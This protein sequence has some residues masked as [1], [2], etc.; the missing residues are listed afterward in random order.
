MNMYNI[1]SGHHLRPHRILNACVPTQQ[2]AHTGLGLKEQNVCSA[3]NAS[4]TT[5]QQ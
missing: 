4:S 2:P 3:M 1:S 5:W